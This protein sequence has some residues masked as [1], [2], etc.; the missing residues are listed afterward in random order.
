MI[1]GLESSSKIASTG[2]VHDLS[3]IP[4]VLSDSVFRFGGEMT[5]EKLNCQV[6]YYS[7]RLHVYVCMSMNSY[8]V[9][10]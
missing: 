8:Q 10:G 5:F 2:W 9:G 4:S 6:K 3:M 1:S 7:C